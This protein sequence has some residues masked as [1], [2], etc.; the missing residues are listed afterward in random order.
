MTKTNTSSVPALPSHGV[1]A[2]RGGCTDYPE[3]TLAAFRAAV[4]LGAAMI[5]LDLRR[6]AD[7]AIIIIHDATVDRTTNGRGRLDQLTF[8]EIR[9]LD[10]GS[11]KHPRFARERIPTLE[12]V[13]EIVPRNV[14]LNLQ[15]KCGEAIAAD[16][17]RRLAAAGRLDHAF[18]AC[19]A[20]A[21]REAREAVPDILICSLE[22]KRSRTAYIAHCIDSGANFIQFHHLR[23]L[24]RPDLVARAADGGLRVN[25][26]CNPR[27]PR[28]LRVLQAGVHFPLV[29]DLAAGLATSRAAP[30]SASGANAAARRGL[31]WPT[32][33]WPWSPPQGDLSF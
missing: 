4:Q 13:L 29:D 21:A 26:V 9:S 2:H 27:R 22:R 18:L 30:G 17:A 10:A 15:I 20:S 11:W 8:A 32:A 1:A 16:V 6:S 31:P 12:E 7:G 25:F 5:E 23:G 33:L 24:P 28:L 3:N 19:G 14:W